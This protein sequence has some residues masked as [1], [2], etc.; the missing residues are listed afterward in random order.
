MPLVDSFDPAR[1]DALDYNRTAN[2]GKHR[3]HRFLGANQFIPAHLELP[4]GKEHAQLVEKW[5]RGE[6]EVPEIADKWRAGAVI[7][8]QVLAP[9]RARPGEAVTVEVA[10][11]NNKAGHD[12]PTGPLDIIQSWVELV[13]TDEKGRE[14]FASGRLDDRYFIEPGSFVF[15]AEPVD[16]YGNLID[17]HNLWEMVGV[18]Y[19]RALFPGYADQARYTFTVP[20]DARRLHVKARLCYRKANQFL[21][22]FLFPDTTITATV[23]E[24]SVDSTVIQV[25]P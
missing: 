6:I 11:L 24:L 3:S 5:L 23:T 19:K 17:R 22:N 16:R 4:G 9:E 15:K 1:G 7:P 21:L 13:V 20:H 12:F 2:D 10:M 8:I 18:R 25:M 14:V